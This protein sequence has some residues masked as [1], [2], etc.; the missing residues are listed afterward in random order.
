MEYVS[1]R[2]STLRGDQKIEFDTYIKINE[3]MIL[4]LRRG[5]S[6]EGERLKRLVARKVRKM[7][8][9]SEAEPQYRDYLRVNIE[10]AY[11]NNS[12]KDIKTRSEIVQGVQTSNVE[13]VFDN[14]ENVAIY[15]ETKD[16]AEKY[17]QFLLSNSDAVN[18][19]MQ[20][21]NTDK[22]LAHHGVSVATLSVALA[23]K[24]E[25]SD[26]KR[27][28]IIA[29][30][31]FLHDIGHQGSKIDL[32]RSVKD[33]SKEEFA[34][35]FI[36]PTTGANRIQDK[37]HFDQGV[38]N[39]I[40]QHEEVLDGSGPAKLKENQQDPH[41]LIVSA[42]NQ[43]DRLITFQGCERVDAGKQFM[44]ERVGLHPLKYMQLLGEILKNIS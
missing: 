12:S 25:I 33:M 44:F 41:A 23:Q 16:S 27:T 24:L 42:A 8:I 11:D 26:P 4:Y 36:H 3:K 28:Q 6:F 40:A 31:A 18:S 35:Y 39:I 13:G 10:S 7:F 29:L 5:D 1:I 19:V 37:K 9:Q 30:G 17:V 22:N 15:M 38:I 2:T 32:C 43:V 14:P 34:E 21:E 20:I